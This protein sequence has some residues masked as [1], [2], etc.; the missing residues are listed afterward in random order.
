[1]GFVWSLHPYAHVRPLFVVEADYPF[2]FLAAFLARWERH[3]VQP[4][5][6]QDSVCAFCNRILKR[7]A[8]L[9]HADPDVVFLEIVHVFVAAVLAAPVAMVYQGVSLP[10]RHGGDSH[11][12][13]FQRVSG[14]QRRAKRPAHD[15]VR[16]G[17]GQERQVAYAL[18]RLHVGDVRHPYLV[19]TVRDNPLYEVRVLSVVVLRVGC[20][21]VTSPPHAYH[22]VVLAQYLDER[23]T[24][25]HVTAAAHACRYHAVQLRAADS[26]IV[27]AQLA[28]RVNDDGFDGVRPEV[29]V[30]SLVERLPAITKQPAEG[31]QGCA[32]KS[33]A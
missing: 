10:G 25:R 8:T 13:R 9:R 3:L 28:C 31:L 1:M 33:P 19:R 15:L 32:R 27:L 20:P 18:V 29:V 12:E 26:G 4:F 14:L 30:A 2:Q 24:S 23:V 7:V 21:V 5:R 22:E 17:V 11:A 16:V 6:F